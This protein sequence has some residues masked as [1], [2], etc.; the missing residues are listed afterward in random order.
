MGKKDLNRQKG[1]ETDIIWKNTD[2][3]IIQS[4]SLKT[5]GILKRCINWETKKGY[6]AI[7]LYNNGYYAL[8]HHKINS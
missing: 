6:D 7:I 8:V 5:G 2:V 3:D 4:G 1:R